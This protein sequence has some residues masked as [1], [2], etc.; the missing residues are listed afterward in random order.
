MSVFCT[1]ID[2]SSLEYKPPTNNRSGGKVVNVSTVKGSNDYKN[3]IRFQMSEDEKTNLQTAVWGLST[4]LTGQDASR[5]TLELTVES[6]QLRSFLESLDETNINTA[7]AQSP[8]WFKKTLEPDA[9]RQM[10]VRLI[11]E[12]SKEG[13]P[14]SMRV[15][16][17]CTEPYATNIYVVSGEDQNGKL[18]YSKGGPED[19]VRNAKCLVVVETVGLWFMSRQFGMSLTATEILVWPSKRCTGIDAFSLSSDAKLIKVE[20]TRE[21]TNDD[22][23][24]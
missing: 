5:R 14:P 21:L 18:M 16:V 20:P 22:M 13:A 2:V 10:Y 3:R 15:K 19:L 24:E 6:S 7:I 23:E 8:D 12:P 4:P 17:K 11:K 1:S 9:I